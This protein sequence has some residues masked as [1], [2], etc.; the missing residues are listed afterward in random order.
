MLKLIY[1]LPTLPPPVE[2]ETV[3]VLKALVT[4]NR[5]LAELKGRAATI[6]NQGILIDSLVLQEAK[7]SSEIENIVTTQ[8]E[9][10]QA[11]LFPDGP[12]SPAAKEV[13]LY[14]AALKLGHDRMQAAQGVITNNTLIDMFRLLKARNDGFRV[15]PGTMLMHDRTGDIVYVPPQDAN[16]IVALMTAIERF[17][18]EDE[19]CP[20]DPLIKMALIHHQFESIHPFPDGNGRIGRILNVL[21]LTRTRLLEIPILYLS[22][23]ITCT[24]GE[25]YRLLQAVRDTNGAPEAWEAWVLYML[26]AV[27]GTAETTLGLVEGIRRQMIDI[28]HRM[29]DNLSKIYSQDLLNNLFRHPYTR[30]EFLVADLG[31]TRQTA[32]KYLDTLAENGFVT[33]RQAGRNNYYINTSL[34]RLFLEVSGGK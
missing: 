22:R 18:N 2:L 7:A 9:L 27:A 21:Y 31:I 1:T 26:Q 5:S 34:V 20:L 15:T 32:A 11:D 4:A 3:P 23:H 19:A 25:Y 14:R 29:R 8:D 13:A 28:K 33:K 24:K 10:F 12:Q 30:I 6:P 17:I 16:E